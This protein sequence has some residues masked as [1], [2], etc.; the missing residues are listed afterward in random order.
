MFH[1]HHETLIELSYIEVPQGSKAKIGFI[2][3]TP[4]DCDKGMRNLR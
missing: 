2:R 1:P 3:K 4:W